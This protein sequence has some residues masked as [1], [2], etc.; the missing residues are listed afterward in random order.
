VTTARMAEP[1][2][3]PEATIEA[4]RDRRCLQVTQLGQRCRNQF[5]FTFMG[6]LLCVTHTRYLT[7]RHKLDIAL[8]KITPPRRLKYP[9]R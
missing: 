8:G 3:V 7:T 1:P 5:C 2:L 4:I 6:T 9:G